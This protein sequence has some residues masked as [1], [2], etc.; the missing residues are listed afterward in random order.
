VHHRTVTVVVRCA[1]SYHIW[2]VRPLVLGVGWHTGHRPV[3]TGQSGVPNRPL[4]RATRRP[5]IEQPTVDAGDRWLTGQSGAPP[6]SLVHHRTVWCTTGQSGAPP[7]SPL[8]YSRTHLRFSES[9]RFTA[10][11]PG[12]PDTVRCST[13]QS[14]VPGQR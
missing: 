10:G 4:L 12:T 1:I 3:H 7:D 8:N 11:Q 9:S 14:G 13:G 6:D 5:R 2:R